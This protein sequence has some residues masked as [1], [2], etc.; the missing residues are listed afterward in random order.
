ML[1]DIAPNNVE[2]DDMESLFNNFVARIDWAKNGAGKR[3][4]VVAVNGDGSL[5]IM[6]VAPAPA[7]V[8]VTLDASV[9]RDPDGDELAFS[10]W[11]LTEAGTYARDV[12]ILGSASNRASVQVPADS[13]GKSFPVVCEATDGGTP[14]LTAYRGI[15]FEPTGTAR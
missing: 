13:A 8:A 3:N 12:T 5:A 15:I 9:F 14:A 10:W 7:G 4:P 6:K 2:P 1:T 11:V